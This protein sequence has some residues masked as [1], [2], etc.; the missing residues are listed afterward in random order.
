VAAVKVFVSSEGAATTKE[1]AL[2]GNLLSL[3][4]D[5]DNLTKKYLSLSQD[6]QPLGLDWKRKPGAVAKFTA[7]LM[8]IKVATGMTLVRL[9]IT[10][11]L[12]R[13][14]SQRLEES[15]NY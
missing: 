14:S 5:Q 4:I 10:P 11:K 9:K 15:T 2:C 8:G 7:S 13:V 3:S 1:K 6:G 12:L